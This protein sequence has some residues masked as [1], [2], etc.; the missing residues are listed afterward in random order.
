MHCLCAGKRASVVK[1]ADQDDEIS[2]VEDGGPVRP[3]SAWGRRILRK[4]ALGLGAV[5]VLGLSYV[6]IERED[7]ANSIIAGQFE[8]MDIPATYEIESIGPDKQVLR[9]VVIGDPQRPDLTVERVEVSIVPQFGLPTIGHATVTRARIYGSYTKGKLSFGALDPIIFPEKS[10]EPTT[11]PDIDL[12]L[13][14]AR[15]LIRSDLGQIGLKA[16]GAGNLESG[17]SGVLAASAPRL[18]A[19]DC[20]I[21]GLTL[22]G[23]VTTSAARPRFAGPMRLKGA[24]CGASGL[25]ARDAVMAL[26]LH[27]DKDFAGLD[28]D[29]KLSAQRLAYGT[30]GSKGLGG[31]AKFIFRDGGLRAKYDLASRGIESPHAALARFKGSGTVRA[32][33]SFARYEWHGDWD[34]Q[35][36]R[37]GDGLNATLASVEK[38]AEGSFLAPIAAQVRRALLREGKGSSF[39]ASTSLRNNDGA[40]TFQMPQGALRGGSGAA[41]LSV[42]RVQV[43]FGGRNGPQLSGNFS[44]GGEGLPQISGRMEQSPRGNAILRLAM[45]EYD[46]GKASLRVPELIVAQRP[47]GAIGFAG[48][49]E[50]DGPL[51]GGMVEKLALPVD[52]NWS[53]TA[54]FSLWR[55]CMRIAFR[56]LAMAGLT[57]VQRNLA[58]CPDGGAILRS[59]RRGTRLAAV[60]KGLDLAGRL[61]ES[62]ARITSGPLRLAFPGA[63]TANDLNVSLGQP[64]QASTFRFAQ[65]SADTAR[66][67]GGTLGGGEVK[68]ASVPLDILDAAG[69][70]HY[71]GGVF[72]LGDANF[73][74]E[75]R[76]QVDRF[77]PL[78]ARGAQ[79]ALKDNVIAAQALLREPK[80]DRQVTRVD[81]RHDLHRGAGHADLFVDD[82]LFDSQVQPAT[83]TTLA[84]GVVANAAGT[85]RGQGRID[86]TPQTV[87]S[88]GTFSTDNFDFAA[89]FGPAKGVSGTVRFTDLLGLVTAPR[90]RLVIKEI[91]PGIPVN[92]GEL[93][94]QLQPGN[95]LSVE[96]ARWPFLGGTLTLQP[97]QMRM[98]VAE[99]RRYVL[100]I[101]GM[102]ASLFLERMELGNISATGTFDGQV[103]IVFDENGGRLEG[104]LLTSRAPGGNFSYVGELTY[105]DLS[106]MANFA[107]AA[108]RSV[109]YK[110]MR[111]AVDGPLTGEIVTRVRFEGVSQGAGT[112]QNFLT[113]QI[114]KLP[115]RFN[116]NIRAPFYN[117][118][119]SVKAMY[120]PAFVRDP[121]ELGLMDEQGRPISKEQRET[122]KLLPPDKK[123]AP[124]AASPADAARPPNPIQQKESENMR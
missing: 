14:D 28:G 44:T 105:K 120:D 117:L 51:P 97:V 15:G 18:K 104:G 21:H 106:A 57:L 9:N 23:K 29:L 66:G 39:A 94:F 60:S 32:R 31:S 70:W 114:A 38:N 54:G 12:R 33:D 59:D 79:L 83:L 86:W 45:P 93:F 40:A 89:A 101:D 61:G 99:T 17:F 122:G 5:M 24:Q 110:I 75:D 77:E 68:L 71:A 73:R 42:S 10:E 98:G 108:L 58:F 3:K 4:A 36:V 26:N 109:D 103:P 34:G 43:R 46:A 80:S 123:P 11:L 88:G 118:I 25:S 47:D 78:V 50:A 82:L 37:L 19:G 55:Q 72:A 96:G 81:I 111:V 107:F 64:G 90:Q 87:T 112:K 7:I 95:I 48:S 52:G 65:F 91:N 30:A 62:P 2:E 84:L 13:V 8:G 1:M 49:I 113:R 124:P 6:W 63:S 67:F 27:G 121:R 35:D 92:D 116:V 100:G 16:Q 69:K 115:V 85:V 53:S 76:E 22:Y 119:T 102:D 74:V 56:K 20:D 41:L